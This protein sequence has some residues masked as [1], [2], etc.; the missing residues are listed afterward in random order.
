MSGANLEDIVKNSPDIQRL[1]EVRSKYNKMVNASTML[2]KLITKKEVLLVLEES[3]KTKLLYHIE[4]IRNA[5]ESLSK[6]QG[7]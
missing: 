3:E 7:D 6:L 2:I 1:I 5:V 4:E